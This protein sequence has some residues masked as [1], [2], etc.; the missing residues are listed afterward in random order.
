[1]QEGAVDSTGNVIGGQDMPAMTLVNLPF[2]RYVC[3]A[4]YDTTKNVDTITLTVSPL[5]TQA[6]P[7]CE[8]ASYSATVIINGDS[9]S[10]TFHDANGMNAFGSSARVTLAG[11]SNSVIID[12]STFGDGYYCTTWYES[13]HDAQDNFGTDSA[14]LYGQ[15][16]SNGPYAGVGRAG[17]D[18]WESVTSWRNVMV[19]QDNVGGGDCCLEGESSECC[20]AC[21]NSFIVTLDDDTNTLT[22]TTE[23]KGDFSPGLPDGCTCPTASLR[24]SQRGQFAYGNLTWANDDN[25]FLAMSATVKVPAMSATME[26]APAGTTIEVLCGASSYDITGRLYYEVQEVAFEDTSEPIVLTEK[27][28][29]AAAAALPSSAAVLIAMVMIATWMMPAV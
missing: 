17:R 6:Y 24:L 7:A 27:S 9:A 29:G 10:G 22:L 14:T 11:D 13:L 15:F 4:L 2:C 18:L 25:E 3:T 21:K 20:D 16:I 5:I 12:Y 19:L 8:C 28:S 23:S 1:M 26:A